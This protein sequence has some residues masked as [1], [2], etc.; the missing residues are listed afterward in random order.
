[1]GTYSDFDVNFGL[2]WQVVGLFSNNFTL[3]PSSLLQNLQANYEI[4]ANV[5]PGNPGTLL[6]SGTA[7]VIVTPTGR[8]AIDGPNTYIEYQF[9]VNNL[10]INLPFGKYYMNVAPI[11]TPQISDLYGNFVFYNSTTVGANSI[12]FT[13]GN[14]YVVIGTPQPMNFILSTEFGSQYRDFSNGVVGF[15]NPICI[16]P[17][18]EALLQDG[19]K[20]LIKNLKP[21]DLL[22]TQNRKTPAKVLINKR[23]DVAHKVMVHIEKDAIKPKVPDSLLII[24]TNHPVIIDNKYLKPRSLLNGSNIKRH[25]YSKPVNT[26]TIITDNGL[27]VYI[28]NLLV[29]TWS[30]RKYNNLYLSPSAPIDQIST[31]PETLTIPQTQTLTMPLTFIIPKSSLKTSTVHKP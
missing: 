30:L 19:T 7:P 12:G 17:N 14:D 2:G 28:N 15:L 25:K 3:V 23:N 11:I 8:T 10:F 29:S 31:I 22:R 6:L 4:R 5:G 26:H 9:L 20:V 16:D 1:M 21:G 27:P 13:G 18:M 24:T